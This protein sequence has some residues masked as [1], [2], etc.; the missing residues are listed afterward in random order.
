MKTFTEVNQQTFDSALTTI[1]ANEL[2]TWKCIDVVCKL[3]IPLVMEGGNIATAQKIVNSL[4]S[5][6]RS[7]VLAF[8]TIMLPYDSDMKTQKFGKKCKNDKTNARTADKYAAFLASKV[9]VQTYIDTVMLADKEPKAV[10]YA[11]RIEQAIAT[12]SKNELK[13]IEAVA[14]NALLNNGTTLDKI[15]AL[16]GVEDVAKAA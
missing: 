16:L 14:I 5:R 9:S 1:R 7:D 15:L 4:K 2:S 3:A 10:D 6:R 12:A 8:L 13:N 11:K